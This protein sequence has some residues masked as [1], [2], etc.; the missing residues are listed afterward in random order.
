LHE[1]AKAGITVRPCEDKFQPQAQGLTDPQPYPQPYPHFHGESLTYSAA[2]PSFTHESAGYEA[3]PPSHDECEAAPPSHGGYRA[4]SRPYGGYRPP[5]NPT[6]RSSSTKY[7]A[8]PPQCNKY[9]ADYPAD[10]FNNAPAAY[11]ALSTSLPPSSDT[12]GWAM[13]VG[14]GGEISPPLSSGTTGWAMG[15]GAGGAVRQAIL[16]DPHAQISWNR[17]NTLLVS[18]Q[19]LNSVA[20][21]GITGM[22]VPPTPVSSESYK[23]AGLPIYKE[24]YE[25]AEKTEGGKFGMVHSVGQMDAMRAGPAGVKLGSSLAQGTKAGCTSCRQNFVDCV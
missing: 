22:V 14:A 15:V 20:W 13:G 19:M 2:F 25:E 23:K 6:A 11:Q 24:Y 1:A 9:D 7:E 4:A 12:T 17:A 18:V 5:Q 8:A 16:K 3:A 21:E 10:R